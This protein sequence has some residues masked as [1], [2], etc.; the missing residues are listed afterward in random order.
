MKRKILSIVLVAVSCLCLCSC[1]IVET[2]SRGNIKDVDEKA[3]KEKDN[4]IRIKA[5]KVSPLKNYKTDYKRLKAT[6]KN[7]G[8]VELKDGTIYFKVY[9]PKGTYLEEVYLNV[10][11][12]KKG[13]TVDGSWVINNTSFVKEGDVCTLE[14]FKYID[15]DNYQ[16]YIN[17]GET[18]K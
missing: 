4:G 9:S 12:F 7:T 3:D 17:T 14:A 10:K 5:T 13:D 15:V 1:G 16:S 11:N 6:I 8:K 2:G 18:L